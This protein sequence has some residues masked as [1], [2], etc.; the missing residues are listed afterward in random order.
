MSRTHRWLIGV[1][2][3]LLLTLA[4]VTIVPAQPLSPAAQGRPRGQY[5]MLPAKQLGNPI[6]IVYV[7]DSVNE[8]LMALRW[9]RA[10]QRLEVVGFRDMINDA[11]TPGKAR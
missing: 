5:V 3:A 9:D 2:A 8:E 7:L 6:G 10:S 11:G 4:L 1:N